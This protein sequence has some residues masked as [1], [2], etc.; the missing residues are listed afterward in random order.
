[1]LGVYKKHPQAYLLYVEDCFLLSDN[2]DTRIFAKDMKKIILNSKAFQET[3]DKELQGFLR[4]VKTGIVTTEYTG[5]I[6]QMIQ[7][8]KRNEQ[9]RKEYHVLPAALM[10]AFDEGE[11]RGKSLGLAE[12]EARGSRQAKL[13][14]A[15]NLLHFGL[16][17]ENIAK[18]TG[19][20]KAEVEALEK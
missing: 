6:E 4:Y 13:E 14:T 15:K 5:R 8:V 16:S 10:D 11:E 17:V 12:G 2:A 18:A 19:L 3:N 1:M 7:T 20:S 9:L